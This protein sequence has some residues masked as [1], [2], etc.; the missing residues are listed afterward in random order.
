MALDPTINFGKA[1]VSTGYDDA[2]TSIVLSSGHGAKLPSSF[3]YNLVWWNSTDYDDPA[4][5]PNVEIVR[6][7]NRSTDTLT[8]TRA[9][10]GTAASTKNTGGKTYKMALAITKKMIDGI[11]GS[12]AGHI[13][14]IPTAYSSITQGTWVTSISST[15]FLNGS[16][17]N[18]SSANGDRINYKVYLAAGT[19]TF[20]LF[21]IT[22]ANAGIIDVSLDGYSSSEGTIDLYSGSTVKNVTKTIPGITVSESGLVDLSIKLNGKN[23]SSSNYIASLSN[24]TLFRTA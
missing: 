14:I 21:C 4:D 10:E 8:V 23:G 6:C 16:F 18:S 12:F 5:D 19:Y 15:Q 1:T 13:N 2:D 11:D 22:S 24:I 17:L 20:N 7:T 9:Q 3:S